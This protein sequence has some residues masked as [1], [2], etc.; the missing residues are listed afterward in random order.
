MSRALAPRTERLGKFLRARISRGGGIAAG[1]GGAR[2]AARL[3]PSPSPALM[4][5]A[6]SVLAFG[7]KSPR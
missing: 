2:Q 7:G 5:G 3:R 1:I 4:P 6:S